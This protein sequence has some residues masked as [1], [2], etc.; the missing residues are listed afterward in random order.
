MYMFYIW[1][2]CCVSKPQFR[3][4]IWGSLV[5]CRDWRVGVNFWQL[6]HHAGVIFSGLKLRAR[7][8]VNGT[9]SA[10]KYKNSLVSIV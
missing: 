3:A 7:T 10:I 4:N 9:S 8:F 2:T 1:C 6:S 5:N